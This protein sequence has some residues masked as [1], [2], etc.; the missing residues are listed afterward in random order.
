MRTYGE[1]GNFWA[2]EHSATCGAGAGEPDADGMEGLWEASVARRDFLREASGCGRPDDA[3]PFLVLSRRVAEASA[4]EVADVPPAQDRLEIVAK[5]KR[6]PRGS[7]WPDGRCV[8]LPF[9]MSGCGEFR[10]VR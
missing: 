2:C 8:L 9:A 1:S 4:A 7:N 3:G 10:M 6:R 5:K